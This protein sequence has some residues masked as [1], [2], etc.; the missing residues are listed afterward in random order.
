MRRF[1][2]TTRLAC[3][4]AA[5]GVANEAVAQ[6]ACPEPTLPA[7]SHNDYERARPLLDAL[8]LGYRGVEA[9][10]FL[11]DGVLRVGH[12][13]RAAR[14]GGTLDS[15]YLAPL[16]DVIARC[17]AWSSPERPFF[18][19][20]EI[21]EVSP[22]T[23]DALLMVLR[24]Y[25]HLWV[26]GPDNR[27]APLDIILVGWHPL[28]AS[29]P[30]DSLPGLQQRIAKADAVWELDSRVRLLSVDYGKTVGRW[31]R[32]AAGRRR[33]T[34]AIRASKAAFPDRLLRVHNVPANAEVH[35]ALFAAGVDLIGTKEID[36]TA[37]LLAPPGSLVR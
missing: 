35:A 32:T 26:R 17:S 9:D 37:R 18:L 25:T 8:S 7:Y 4:L 6:P 11:I 23:Y 20:V 13:R 30:A 31:W 12:D 21:K 2:N 16:A 19:A 24:R 14:S 22:A 34:E 28:I 10:V 29:E 1:L 33:W 27:R 36:A 15:V 5:T 3:A